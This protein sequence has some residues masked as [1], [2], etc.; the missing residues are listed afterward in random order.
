ML[1]AARKLLASTL[2]WRMT[3]AI[4]FALAEHLRDRV[5]HG[6]ECSGRGPAAD[7]AGPPSAELAEVRCA[8]EGARFIADALAT[9]SLD[10]R[11]QEL[12][13][14]VSIEAGSG[15]AHL[16]ADAHVVHV[17]RT[18]LLPSGLGLAPLAQRLL[19]RAEDVAD[20]AR[21]SGPGSRG[22]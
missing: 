4:L 2:T 3:A 10:S 1:S 19:D 20:G 22:P 9:H 21:R 7:E 14:P 12:Q 8:T 15:H 17:D 11:E 6:L 16:H 18:G 13:A 5:R